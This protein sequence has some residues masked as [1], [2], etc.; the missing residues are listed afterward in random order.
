MAHAE[1]HVCVAAD[2]T[3]QRQTCLIKRLHTVH[4]WRLLMPLTV[5]MECADYPIMR[6]ILEGI[7]TGPRPS[8][9]SQPHAEAA[10]IVGA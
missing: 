2:P 5:L 1:P 9:E 8:T 6:R 3:E 10:L 7:R 4:E